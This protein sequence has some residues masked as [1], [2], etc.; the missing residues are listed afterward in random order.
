[1]ARTYRHERGA[2]SYVHDVHAVA[3]RLPSM[4]TVKRP[5]H[6]VYEE[7]RLPVTPP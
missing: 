7:F 2:M 6:S 5:K 3:I 4:A 1:M